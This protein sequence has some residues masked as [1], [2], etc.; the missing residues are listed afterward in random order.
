MPQ[1]K[2][3]QIQQD[4]YRLDSVTKRFKEKDLKLYQIGNLW[5]HVLAKRL[6]QK[7][8][9]CLSNQPTFDLVKRYRTMVKNYED[10]DP[11]LLVYAD[12]MRP[13]KRIEKYHIKVGST[14][15]TVHEEQFVPMLRKEELPRF[16]L[17]QFSRE[18]KEVPFV[19]EAS[20]FRLWQ[21]DNK[22][23]LDT[24]MAKDLER[25]KCHKFI[26]D[27]EDLAD[28]VMTIKSNFAELKHV[29]CNLIS[30]EGYPHIGW[31]DF[32]KFAVQT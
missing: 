9:Q 10:A 25:W 5:Y 4:A 14:G 28:V 11:Q 12:Y 8:Y 30:G 32:A 21:Q 7:Q 26:K 18:K 3:D 1:A 17:G 15:R 20:V 29:H 27:E 23:I 24:T 2:R 6:M 13:N 19:K 16:K 31:M 22:K